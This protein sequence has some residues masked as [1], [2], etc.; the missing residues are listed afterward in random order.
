MKTGL[1]V[2]A[3]TRLC[4]ASVKGAVLFQT[5]RRLEKT[6]RHKIRTEAKGSIYCG[7]YVQ[8]G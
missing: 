2:P 5:V 8:H 7:A 3:P 6:R 4:T 1:V